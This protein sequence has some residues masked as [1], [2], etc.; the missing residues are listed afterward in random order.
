MFVQHEILHHKKRTP[1]D[2]VYWGPVYENSQI[3]A[4]LQGFPQIFW[5]KIEKVE[6][7]AAKELDEGKIVGWFQGRMEMG[8]RALGA[9]SILADPRRIGLRDEINA[10]IKNRESFRPFAPSVL[11]EEA[12]RFFEISQNMPSPFMLMTFN[13]RDEKRQLIPAVVHVDGSSRLQTVSEEDNPRYYQLLRKFYEKTGIP[14][15]LN[16]SFN[17]AGEPIVNNPADAVKCF[18]KCGMDV[19]FV[20]DYMILPRGDRS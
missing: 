9:R 6:D 18:L 7:R 5:K 8:P 13:T 12:P 19:L 15:I 3:E 14:L 20:E 1:V 4:V 10:M 16:T 11:A 17:R 2:H